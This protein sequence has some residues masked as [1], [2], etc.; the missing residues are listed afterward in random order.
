[1]ARPRSRDHELPRYLARKGSAYYFVTKTPRRWIKLGSDK[2]VALLQHRALLAQLGY[3]APIAC[4]PEGFTL[5]SL[6]RSVARSAS[7]RGIQNDLTI[8]DVQAL[9]TRAGGRC[10]VTRVP[11]DSARQEGQRI[12]LFIPSID[13]IDSAQGYSPGNC[14]LV[15]AGVN[16]ALNRFGDSFLAILRAPSFVE[17]GKYVERGY[18]ENSVTP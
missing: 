5:A 1:M 10:E 11:F 4:L 2:A 17:A 16:V 12:R 8:A 6:M 13:R 14:R 3:T 9:V 15:C 7:V 18:R